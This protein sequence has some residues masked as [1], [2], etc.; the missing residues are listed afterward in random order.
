MANMLYR[1][2]RTA[3]R[4]WPFFLVGWLIAL[5]A[6]GGF[7]AAKSRPMTSQFTIPGIPSLQAAETQKELFPDQPAADKQV[8]G[9]LPSD[10]ADV[11]TV[12]GLDV[13]GESCVDRRGRPTHAV[14]IGTDAL[15]D[16]VEQV[17]DVVEVVSTGRLRAALGE[18]HLDDVVGAHGVRRHLAAALDGFERV[19]DAVEVVVDTDL[20]IADLAGV[21]A[22]ELR[23]P[24]LM[25]GDHLHIPSVTDALRGQR[26][27]IEPNHGRTWPIP[28]CSEC[29]LPVTR[30]SGKSPEAAA[31]Q[32]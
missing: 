27:L 16:P 21:G 20:V 18:H 31:P 6:L 22:V 19:G 2:G 26:F 29:R 5:L 25:R 3:Y 12:V 10:V 32:V 7:A 15:G 30:R 28:P 17:V 13:T 1:L 23:R 4:K 11:T 14:L 8:N 24:D 9:G